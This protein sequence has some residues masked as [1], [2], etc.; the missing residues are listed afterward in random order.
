M[1]K[2]HS[3]PEPEIFEQVTFFE[4]EEDTNHPL[5]RK[6]D[7][8]LLVEPKSASMRYISMINFWE[9]GLHLAKGAA[10]IWELGAIGF[11]DKTIDSSFCCMKSA[12]EIDASYFP[13][14]CSGDGSCSV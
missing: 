4:S 12:R 1:E 8:D 13:T 10:S 11:N 7:F 9:N 2:G 14:V 3:L 5:R 6:N